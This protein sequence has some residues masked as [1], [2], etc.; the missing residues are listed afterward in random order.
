MHL[1]KLV[2]YH[3]L[4]FGFATALQFH[5]QALGLPVPYHLLLALPYALTLLVLAGFGGRLEPPAALGQ[6]YVRD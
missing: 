4:F 2:S 3:S 1:R 6:P 5:F